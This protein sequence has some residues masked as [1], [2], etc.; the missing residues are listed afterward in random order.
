MKKVQRVCK[1]CGRVFSEVEIHGGP[2]TL[3]NF[4]YSNL[5]RSA[6]CPVCGDE[7]EGIEVDEPTKSSHL[8]AQRL[9][10]KLSA[11]LEADH[12]GE[13]LAVEPTTGDYV[14]AKTHAEVVQKARAKF[15]GK[16]FS[17]ERIGGGSPF[18]EWE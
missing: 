16:A 3:S 5:K 9:L 10:Q 11:E 14:L 15:G 8:V 12:S 17:V 13:L 18:P 1:G 7:V 6:L 2:P 4:A